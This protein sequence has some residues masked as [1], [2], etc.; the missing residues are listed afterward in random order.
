MLRGAAILAGTLGLAALSGLNGLDRIARTNLA[1]AAEVPMPFAHAALRS[2]G[3]QALATRR[4]ADAAAY[5]WHALNKAPA[6]AE[7]VALFAA[8]QLAQG[9]AAMAERAFTLAG[10]MGWRVPLT[11]AYWLTR[12]IEARDYDAAAL[13]L[14]ALLRQQ[15]S[16]VGQQALLDPVERD[17]EARA[18]LVARIDPQTAWLDKYLNEVY[19][20]T[21]DALRQRA[22]LMIDAAN[23]GQVLGCDRLSNLAAAMINQRL[24][25]EAANLW[26]AQCPEARGPMLGGEGFAGLTLQGTRNPFGWQ[27][28]SSGDV[29]LG[30]VPAAEGPGLRL[31]VDGTPAVTRRFLAKLLLL[32]PGRYRVSWKA[33]SGDGGSM[34][35]QRLRASMV[36]RGAADDW[37]QFPAKDAGGRWSIEATVAPGC[38]AQVLA[39]ALGGGGG[40]LWLEDV[41]LDQVP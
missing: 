23:D 35:P 20:L 19:G 1:A 28:D 41:R 3:Q 24:Y 38:Q 13:R 11:Q 27:V 31:T 2:L 10:R 40:S 36:C 33:G 26:A 37:L 18:A 29:L 17:P 16:L 15:P 6:D 8:G 9:N 14:D 25:S 4:S 12:A 34:A 30:T 32:Q 22:A 39:F 5:G 21:P 7:A